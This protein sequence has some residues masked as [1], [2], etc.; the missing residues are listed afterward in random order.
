[1]LVDLF[2][3]YDYAWICDHQIYNPLIQ[4]RIYLLTDPS[5]QSFGVYSP[6]SYNI[7][8]WIVI[9][10]RSILDNINCICGLSF[11][12]SAVAFVTPPRQAVNPTQ[13]TFTP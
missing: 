6:T 9:I 13:L 12:T 11:D 7:V 10:L 1:V 4:I 5:V 3:L 2:E 8:Q